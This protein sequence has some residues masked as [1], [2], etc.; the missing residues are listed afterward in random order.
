MSS[1]TNRRTF[2]RKVGALS[3]LA[4]AG[5]VLPA[6][7]ASCVGGN[8]KQKSPG[9][10]DSLLAGDRQEGDLFFKISLAQWSLHRALKSGELDNLDFPAKTKNTW[11]IDAVEYVNQFFM[12][13][14]RDKNYL[15]E[16]KKRCEDLGVTSVRIMI[17]EEGDLGNTNQSERM[18]AV[19]NHYKWVEAAQFLGCSDIRVNAR[20]EG[21]EEEVAAAA[22]DGLKKLTAFASDYG[23]AIIVEN[24]GG[25]SSNGQWL[26]GVM[27]QVDDP[28]CGTLPDFG[29]FCIERTEPKDDTIEAYMETRCLEEYDMYQGV[30]EMMP[31]AKGVSAKSYAFDDLGNDTRIDYGKMLQ[32]VKDAGYSGYIGIEYEGVGNISEEEGIRNT[33]ELLKK[34]GGA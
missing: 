5:G 29:N 8:P 15:G 11:G 10:R 20:G 22:A 16:L 32:I 2:I 31:F 12:D 3:L 34:A 24:H 4:G 13:K 17:D 27:K 9:E 33:L 14:A 28:N 1:N 23:I 18:K 26:A 30:A 6:S 7:L 19:E 25:Y 21:S